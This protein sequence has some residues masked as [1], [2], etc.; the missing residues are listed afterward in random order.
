MPYSYTLNTTIPA[1]AA[2]VYRAWLD[3]QAHSEMTGSKATM[4]AVPGAE[5]A[6]RDGYISGRNLELVPPERIVQSWR[7]TK[8]EDGPA[9]S[10]SQ[11][12][13]S[14]VDGGRV[15]PPADP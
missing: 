3:S 6:A 13:L 12:T 2:E 4:S 15:C 10:V 7:T 11:L 9:G 1:S 5:G 14:Q 8:F